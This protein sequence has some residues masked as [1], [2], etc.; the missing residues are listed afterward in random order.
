[1]TKFIV[2]AGGV[3]SGVGKGVTTASIAKILVEYGYKVTTVK[4]DPYINYDAGTLRPTEHGEVWVTDDGGEID[5]D[6][7]NYERFLNMEISKRNNITTGQ[8][9]K[10]IIDKERKGK[11]LGKTV[12]FIPHV[13]EEIKNRLKES[14][15]GYDI[16][17]VEI[18]G[19]IGDYENIPFLFAMKSLERELGKDDVS[20]VLV[21]YL[22]VPS[23]IEEMKTKPTQ[24][25]IRLLSETGIVPDFIVCRAK[26]PLDKERK[27]KI[28]VYANIPS[29][30]VIS[31]PDI[32]TI[33][34][35]PLDLEKEQLGI[36][37]LKELK[38]KPKR[39]PN[40]NEWEKL[41]SKIKNP[42][43]KIK[44]AIVGKYVDIGDYNLVDS[45]VSINE[46]LKHAAAVLDVGVEI[47]WIDSKK[48]E[49]N[50][51]NIN[52]LK[53]CSGIIIPGGFGSSGVEGKVK[54]INYA[55]T[56]NIPFLG[57]CYGLQ[58]AVV[59]FARNVCNLENANTTENDE[60]TK[61]PVIG[62]LPTQKKLM[63]KGDYGG[64]MR[65]G[66]YA[67][68]LKEKSKVLHLYKETGRLKED[69]ERLQK[70]EKD[71]SQAF[72]LGI[73]NG[74]KNIVLERH[75]HR[76]E[77]NPK[78]IKELE[79]KGL[80]FSG[81]HLRKD[82]T[83]LMEFIELPSHPFMISTQ[84]HPEFKSRLGNPSPL[85]YGFVKACAKQ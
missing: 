23:H 7:G 80:V 21:T 34:S 27:Q 36:K 15:N 41:V 71:K 79:N 83:K 3:M 9:Y 60:K 12:Q 55:R 29:E 14:G 17:V 45:Y 37:I 38:L 4:I 67:A 47:V 54:A 85:F 72:R 31:E 77:V 64:T 2:V 5:Q 49:K 84:S 53:D 28:E 40:W 48:F 68:V 44:V 63:E 70:L 46:S 6:L 33:Y 32:D 43:K 20:Y 57:L 8:I 51:S 1:M 10:T 35:I 13:P 19:T 52:A 25:A 11:F 75:R 18:G 65:L 16:V 58:L 26:K 78:F 62:I 69:N 76:Y 82:G 74:H 59:E 22:P 50:E 56:N 81:Y 30:Y 61:F 24:Q 66:A 42:K 73:L 39:T